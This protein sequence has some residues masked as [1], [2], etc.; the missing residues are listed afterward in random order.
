[1]MVSHQNYEDFDPIIV[2]DTVSQKYRLIKC[3]SYYYNEAYINTEDYYGTHLL[4]IA[5]ELFSDAE[6]K[7]VLAWFAKA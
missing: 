1:L 3:V 6:A 5:E 7:A 2:F 4:E